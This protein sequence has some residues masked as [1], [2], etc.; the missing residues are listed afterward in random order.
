[1]TAG[2]CLCVDFLIALAA[3]AFLCPGMHSNGSGR[4]RRV[5]CGGIAPNLNH[6]H[7]GRTINAHSLPVK[8]NGLSSGIGT[9][10][11][12]DGKMQADVIK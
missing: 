10:Y 8:H 9:G 11:G 6:V 1:M 3:G 4:Y 12:F 2:G 5:C 7:T